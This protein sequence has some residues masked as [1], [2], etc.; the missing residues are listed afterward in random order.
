MLVRFFF[1]L[2]LVWAELGGQADGFGFEGG[3]Y[4]SFEANPKLC[5]KSD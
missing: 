2:H 3:L 1:Q 5:L 4:L